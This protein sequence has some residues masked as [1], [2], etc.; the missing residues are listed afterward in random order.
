MTQQ[1][2]QFVEAFARG[3]QI[4]EA[5]SKHKN[6]MTNGDLAKATNLPPSTISRL[7]YTAMRLGYLRHS[8]TGRAYELT[9][10]SLNLGYS[11]LTGIALI[12][13]AAPVLRAVAEKT[14]QTVALCVR[15]GLYVTF[16]QV[17]AGSD[18]LAVRFSVG[19]RLPIATSA[20]GPALLAIMPEKQRRQ[21]TSRIR[22]QLTQ[23]NGN[24]AAFNAALE[25][26]LRNQVSVSRDTWRRGIGGVAIGIATPHEQAAITIPFSTGS[27]SEAHMRS[28]LTPVLREAVA[29]LM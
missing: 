8:E 25:A 2:R 17:V 11:V 4:F 19:G 3:L 10:K 26:A 6:A 21:L 29:E 23:Q 13:R 27:I 7:T 28:V 1:D 15:D 16:V 18:L 5:L 20:A 14:S 9:P 24:V 12:D 22:S